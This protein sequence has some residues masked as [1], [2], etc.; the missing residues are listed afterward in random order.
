MSD[1][2]AGVGRIYK[3]LSRA[4][5]SKHARVGRGTD[6]PDLSSRFETLV[7]FQNI[8]REIFNSLE[9]EALVVLI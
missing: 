2:T 8:S 7:P 5:I 4:R 1:A 6:P 9:P 3:T